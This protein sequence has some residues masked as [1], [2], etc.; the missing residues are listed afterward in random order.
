VPCPDATLAQD[1][2]ILPLS[3]TSALVGVVWHT[4]PTLDIYSYAGLEKVDA[5]FRNAGT[6]PFGY[7]NPLDNNTG[8]NIE[9]SPAATCNGNTSEVR[10]YTVGFYD[11]IMRG[12]LRHGQSRRAVFLQ[13]ALRVRGRRRRSEDGRQYRHDPDPVLSLLKRLDQSMSKPKDETN[14]VLVLSRIADV[15][16]H[17]G[18]AVAGAMCGTFVAAQLTRLNPALF[19]SIGFIAATVLVGMIGFYLGI[20]VPR[21]RASLA[22]PAIARPRV[23]PIQLLSASGTFLATVAALNSLYA[24]V[25]DEAPRRGWGYMVACWWLLG[26]ATQI[27]AGVA[28]RLSLADK[29]AG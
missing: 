12:S 5:A 21:L 11:T 15:V 16:E 29:A 9:N 14:E 1:G 19:D 4:L 25:F 13:P 17:A 24:L 3:V 10:Q 2:T 7:G 8:C 27:G 6:V 26:V 18:F 23:D 28:G 20:D 22:S